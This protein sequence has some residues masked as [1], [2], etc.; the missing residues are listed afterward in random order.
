MVQPSTRAQAPTPKA[1]VVPA[2]TAPLASLANLGPKSAAFLAAAGIHTRE[3]LAALGSVAAFAK[4]KQLEPRASLNLLW[5]LE[6]ALSGLH[7]RVVASEHRTSLLLALEHQQQ[8][9]RPP[10]IR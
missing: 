3:Q 7:W 9:A 6:G 1:V 5:A 8:Q 2:E 4:V 10:S